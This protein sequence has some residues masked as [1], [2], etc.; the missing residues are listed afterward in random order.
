L[1]VYL[2]E[3]NPITNLPASAAAASPYQRLFALAHYWEQFEAHHPQGDLAEFAG[4]LL[5]QVGEASVAAPPTD[6]D[7]SEDHSLYLAKEAPNSTYAYFE[8]GTIGDRIA[9]MISRIG[10]I[11]RIHAR[12][13]VQ[14]AGL[15]GIDEMGFLASAA[16]LNHPTKS[17]MILLNLVEVT[18]GTEIMR[19]LIRQGLL[20]EHPDPTDRRVKRVGITAEG[21]NVLREALQGVH[22]H[23]FNK[24]EP[25]PAG[26]QQ[27]L[28]GLLG[29]INAQMT[30]DYLRGLLPPGHEAP[31]S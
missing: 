27:V 4:W 18:T 29:Q 16:H 1:A 6:P 19:R 31:A 23:S 30:S 17:E 3:V 2:G 8:Q 14:P 26:E 9:M 13:A 15:S 12:K 10:K 7:E 22:G 25:I 20:T 21:R 5:A 28:L 24:W 11:L